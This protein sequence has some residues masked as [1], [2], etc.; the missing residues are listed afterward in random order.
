M[1]ETL[2]PV[3]VCK[4][5]NAITSAQGYSCPIVHQ[6]KVLRKHTMREMK[7]QDWRRWLAKS[8]ICQMR[9]AH[10]ICQG[11]FFTWR[12]DSICCQ[13]CWCAGMNRRGSQNWNKQRRRTENWTGL[14]NTLRICG[15]FFLISIEW[16]EMHLVKKV[17]TMRRG[18]KPKFMKLCRVRRNWGEF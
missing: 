8:L 15:C 4:R 9:A 11:N 17:K 18:L 14:V 7:V 10:L 13:V 2:L 5:V 16:E 3:V 1:G 12:R 6:S